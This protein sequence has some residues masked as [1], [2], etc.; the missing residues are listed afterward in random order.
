MSGWARDYKIHSK[1][2]I[3]ARFISPSSVILHQDGVY[4][5]IGEGTWIGHFTVLDGSNG[6]KIGKNCDISCGVHIYTHS[7]HERCALGGEKLTG[8]VVI[9]DNVVI[10]ANSVINYGCI[11]G[12]NVVV[13]ALSMVKP[14]TVVGSYSFWGGNPAHFIKRLKP[15]CEK[16]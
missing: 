4:P 13:G 12:S 11:I 9:G 6:L 2:R 14:N 5:E 8:E 10:G 7:T 1:G 16:K 3:K 15:K